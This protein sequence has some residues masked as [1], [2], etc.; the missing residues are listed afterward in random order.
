MRDPVLLVETGQ[1]YVSLH[2]TFS[3]QAV[4]T[5]RNHG[6]TH[7]PH[8]YSITSYVRV[9]LFWLGKVLASCMHHVT[10]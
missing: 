1:T 7:V 3:L 6:I 2:A 5:P 9:C 10:E 8:I 4:S